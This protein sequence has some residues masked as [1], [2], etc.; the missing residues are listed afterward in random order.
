METIRHFVKNPA[1]TGIIWLVARL[2]IGYEFITAGLEKIESG[3]WIGGDAISGFLKG[4]LGKASGDHPEVMGWYTDLVNNVF[5]P[6]ATIFST[7][8]AI[9]EVAV[10]VALVLGIVTKFAAFW[11]AVMNFSFL[12]AGVSSSNPQMLVLEVAMIFGGAG[13]AFYGVDKFLMPYLAKA[14]HINREVE[15]TTKTGGSLPAPRPVS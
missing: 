6:N 4:A 1:Y 10:G 2:F 14:L 11:G 7:L 9:G 15:P 13:V 3:T 12:A 5:M 8:V